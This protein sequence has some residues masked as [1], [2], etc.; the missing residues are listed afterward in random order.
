MHILP[1]N[2]AWFDRSFDFELQNFSIIIIGVCA[3][4]N[5]LDFS[6]VRIPFVCYISPN[7][8]GVV[9]VLFLSFDLCLNF[10]KGIKLFIFDCAA[11][12]FKQFDHL[13]IIKDQVNSAN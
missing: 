1:F 3:T 10:V 13:L 12:S 11:S 6:N 5:S 8:I 2:I 7:D 4:K 9:L